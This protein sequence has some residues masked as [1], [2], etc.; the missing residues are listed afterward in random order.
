MN[1]V[2]SIVIDVPQAILTWKHIGEFANKDLP[3]KNRIRERQA[4]DDE[5]E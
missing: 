1:Q 3:C 5:K 2:A 4:W